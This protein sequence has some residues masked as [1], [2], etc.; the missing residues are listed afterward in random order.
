MEKMLLAVAALPG[1]TLI[2]IS[3]ADEI[4]DGPKGTGKFAPRG[5]KYLSNVVDAQIQCIHYPAARKFIQKITF[6]G[7]D[8]DNNGEE[9]EGNDFMDLA[10]EMGWE[11]SAR[12]MVSMSIRMSHPFLGHGQIAGAIPLNRFPSVTFGLSVGTL[13]YQYSARLSQ[14]SYLLWKMGDLRKTYTLRSNI[15]LFPS[16]FYYWRASGT[17]THP[18]TYMSVV[19]AQA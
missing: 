3:R 7:F 13:G 15:L 6:D 10:E 5:F 8:T 2:C 12:R 19:I 14:T 17:F 4:F 16:L 11:W 9:F 18:A 1:A